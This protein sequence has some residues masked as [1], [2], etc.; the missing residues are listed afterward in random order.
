MSSKNTSDS[1]ESPHGLPLD[2]SYGILDENQI[3]N[4]A[5]Q[6]CEIV[7]YAGCH[8]KQQRRFS[9]HYMSKLC[10]PVHL[11][12]MLL[13]IM[14]LETL[15]KKNFML[16]PPKSTIAHKLSMRIKS[17]NDFSIFSCVL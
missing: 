15:S 12:F 3:K 17:D 7:Y 13:H 1:Q 14:L 16:C 6:V 2:V 10:L 9:M 11:C 8:Q 4:L 5:G